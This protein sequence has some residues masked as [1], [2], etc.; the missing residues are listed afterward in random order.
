MDLPCGVF[1]FPALPATLLPTHASI[2]FCIFWCCYLYACLCTHT[3]NL[4]FSLQADPNDTTWH[5]YLEY[6]DQTVLD[7]LFQSIQCSLQYLLKN[8]E[9][10][11]GRGPL[12]ECKM[13]LQIPEIIVAPD[14]DQVR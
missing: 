8:T 5:H 11:T 6:L 1:V 13:E 4:F 10:G 12:L 9:K 3:C 7:G 2:I 14:L